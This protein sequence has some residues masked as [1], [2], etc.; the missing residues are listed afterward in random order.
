MANH[1][2]ATCTSAERGKRDYASG[3][4][5]ASSGCLSHVQVT[6]AFA[7]SLL[8]YELSKHLEGVFN[9]RGWPG[10]STVRASERDPG[11]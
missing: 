10:C 11:L 6:K 8:V 2:P 7:A 5:T 3:L 1:V 4:F 9:M